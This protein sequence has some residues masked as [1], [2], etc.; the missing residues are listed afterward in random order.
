MD[1]FDSGYRQH[2]MELERQSKILVQYSSTIMITNQF[3]VHFS[4]KYTSCTIQ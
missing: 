3:Y 1:N 2:S 4:P